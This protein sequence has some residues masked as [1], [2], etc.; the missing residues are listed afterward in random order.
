VLLLMITQSAKGPFLLSLAMFLGAVLVTRVY[1]K[2][3]YLIDKQSGRILAKWGSP[4]LR[5]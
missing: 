1:D 5:W 2:Q 4:V 3:Y